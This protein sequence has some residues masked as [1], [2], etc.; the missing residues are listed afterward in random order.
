MLTELFLRRLVL[1]T[2]RYQLSPVDINLIQQK[3]VDLHVVLLNRAYRLQ[4]VFGFQDQIYEKERQNTLMI[5][6]LSH[7]VEF[8]NGESGQHVIHI[9]MLTSE[10]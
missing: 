10:P 5:D 6:I 7:I 9:R 4:A 2:N 1:K 8:R 3:Q